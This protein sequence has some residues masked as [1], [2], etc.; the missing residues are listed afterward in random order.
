MGA[1][2]KSGLSSIRLYIVFP[3]HSECYIL[4]K[5]TAG[6]NVFQRPYDLEN[7]IFQKIIILY[8]KLHLHYQ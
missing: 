3:L 5:P 4:M 7:V 2:L 6:E 8:H 1:A